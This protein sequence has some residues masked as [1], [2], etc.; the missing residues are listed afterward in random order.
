MALVPG[1]ALV[2]PGYPSPFDDELRAVAERAGVA[3]RVHLCGW[4]GDADLE[5]LY[6][7]ATCLAFPSL[8]E[9][10]GLPVLEA[11]ARS[12]PVACSGVSALPEVAG[13]A[14]L[15]FDPLSTEA[16]A[17][18]VAALL[19]D[20]ALRARLVA[21]GREQ[22]ARFSWD[23]TARDTVASYERTLAGRPR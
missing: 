22:A 18:A 9:G 3:D 2:L 21:R 16:I 11:M 7:A 4:V 23:R 8:A 20:P 1:A 17:G 10:F 19:H 12:L 14:A 5:G 6:R 15:L 13:D